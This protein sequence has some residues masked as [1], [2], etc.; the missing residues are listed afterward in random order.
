[1]INDKKKQTFFLVYLLN[2]F[3]YTLHN[4][5][6]NYTQENNVLIRRKEKP[7]HDQR[8]HIVRNNKKKV[9]TR[10]PKNQSQPSRRPLG[11]SSEPRVYL[12]PEPTAR[13]VLSQFLSGAK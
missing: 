3:S 1:L 7:L 13:F 9:N 2:F 8:N 12:N 5:A 6:E 4:M 10:S 11:I